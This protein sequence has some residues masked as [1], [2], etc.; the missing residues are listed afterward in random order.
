MTARPSTKSVLSSTDRTSILPTWGFRNGGIS[1]IKDEGN[2]PKY[3]L[4]QQFGHGQGYRHSH[5]DHSQYRQRRQAVA[6][7]AAGAAEKMAAR[8]IRM[9][10]TPVAGH[11]LLV[12]MPACVPWAIDD[13]A[14]RHSGGITAKTHAH[15][16]GLFAVGAGLFKI[17]VQ[18]KRPPSAGTPGPPAA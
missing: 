6:Q 1:R 3:G 4:S 18:V 14:R 12:M 8:V 7:G 5:K 10:E 11:K 17:V 2:P 16:Q 13:A 9:G 15:G